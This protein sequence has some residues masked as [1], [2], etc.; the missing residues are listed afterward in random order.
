MVIQ[1]VR[2]VKR[3]LSVSV[4]PYKLTEEEFSRLVYPD[5]VED[6]NLRVKIDKVR[7]KDIEYNEAVSI[8][9]AVVMK[10]VSILLAL[11]FLAYH[12]LRYAQKLLIGIS[13]VLLHM[14]LGL[15]GRERRR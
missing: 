7:G 14:P 15:V 3:V 13:L 11:G 4:L 5:M 12:S 6:R 1:I 8:H 10:A 2:D 9:R